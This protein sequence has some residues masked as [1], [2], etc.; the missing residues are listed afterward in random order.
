[1]SSN[2]I[3]KEPSSSIDP[4]D[5]NLGSPCPSQTRLNNR[6][7]LF[8][9]IR[10]LPRDPEF[11]SLL[12]P[13]QVEE[14]HQNHPKSYL[15]C[16]HLDTDAIINRHDDDFVRSTD[17]LAG[18]LLDTYLHSSSRHYGFPQHDKCPFNTI[19]M[20][21]ILSIARLCT[22][23]MPLCFFV[24]VDSS[25]N[26]RNCADYVS[27]ITCNTYVNHNFIIPRVFGRD[28]HSPMTRDLVA[29]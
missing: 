2:V 19:E 24:Y 11:P 12:T 15:L 22:S 21:W 14:Q 13:Y 4:S 26:S 29:A 6:P 3:S 9:C 5:K 1:M 7:Q 20:R 23:P 16:Q 18:H 10:T 8:Q 25:W 28:A 17:V 27:Q